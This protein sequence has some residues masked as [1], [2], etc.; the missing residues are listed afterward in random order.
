MWATSWQY[1]SRTCNKNTVKDGERN[2]EL[3][4]LSH[5]R[6]RYESFVLYFTSF[7]VIKATPAEQAIFLPK[8][9]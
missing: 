7:A 2:R 1:H 8:L 4:I 3:F 5:I 6:Y 9:L